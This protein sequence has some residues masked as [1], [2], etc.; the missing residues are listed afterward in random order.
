MVRDDEL[1]RTVLDCRAA[2]YNCYG[3]LFGKS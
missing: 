3:E 2:L 1:R